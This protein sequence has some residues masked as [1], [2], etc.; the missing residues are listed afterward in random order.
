[1]GI[2]WLVRDQARCHPQWSSQASLPVSKSQ[3]RQSLL[4]RERRHL[5]SGPSLNVQGSS[6]AGTRERVTC[7]DLALCTVQDE[8]V[9]G[10]AEVTG[11]LSQGEMGRGDG[12]QTG[13]LRGV[14]STFPFIP[15]RKGQVGPFLAATVD[16]LFILSVLQLSH[17][18]R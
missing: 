8:G 3:R 18:T 4:T 15:G 1:M 9:G 13:V 10:H 17:R 16:K 7:A 14:L 2:R 5:A 6:K 12:G 11:A